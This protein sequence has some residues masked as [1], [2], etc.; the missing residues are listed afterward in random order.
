MRHSVQHIVMA[1]FSKQR[2]TIAN[3][4][5]MV[6]HERGNPRPPPLWVAEHEGDV[7]LIVASVRH[8]ERKPNHYFSEKK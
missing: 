7:G 6:D 5:Q 3:L 8:Q 4:H 1:A 2:S